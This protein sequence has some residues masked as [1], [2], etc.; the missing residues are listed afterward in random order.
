MVTDQKQQTSQK[1]NINHNNI[2]IQA[3]SLWLILSFTFIS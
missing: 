3:M 2:D 1:G